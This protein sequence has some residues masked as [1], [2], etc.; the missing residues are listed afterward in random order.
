MPKSHKCG[1]IR[2]KFGRNQ[3]T[4]GQN[5]PN[6]R[7]RLKFGRRRAQTI[8]NRT[9]MLSNS[10]FG[11]GA[12]I[13]PSVVESARRFAPRDGH[14]SKSSRRCQRKF[15]GRLHTTYLRPMGRH[16]PSA[17]DRPKRWATQWRRHDSWA[18]SPATSAGACGVRGPAEKTESPELIAAP[19]PQ[20]ERELRK[21][22]YAAP[23][24]D[25]RGDVRAGGALYLT[26]GGKSVDKA[27]QRDHTPMSCYTMWCSPPSGPTP[28]L[29]NFGRIYGGSPTRFGPQRVELGRSWPM[30]VP[31][32]R[33]RRAVGKC[34]SNPMFSEFGETWSIRLYEYG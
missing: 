24:R 13:G 9:H 33:M 16:T 8:R 4:L 30:S 1:P 3:T 14:T 18:A 6:R 2:A 21:P 15:G 27:H 19:M 28:N 17:K 12:H 23:G 5:R 31:I 26:G 25:T 34:R 11:F 22:G 29:V 7:T 32:L 10:G 20:Q